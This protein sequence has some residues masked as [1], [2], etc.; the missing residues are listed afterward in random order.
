M[1][2]SDDLLQ[3][4]I[5]KQGFA[6]ADERDHQAEYKAFKSR[7]TEKLC[8]TFSDAKDI[9]S[10]IFQKLPQWAQRNDLVGWV[11]ASDAMSPD[12]AGE[13]ARLSKENASL[14][15]AAAESGA[16][17]FDGVSFEQM[18]G[19]LKSD[20]IRSDHRPTFGKEVV[21]AGLAFEHFLTQLSGDLTMIG[22]MQPDHGLLE[23]LVR[24]GLVDRTSNATMNVFKLT[25]TGRR[26]RNRLMAMGESRL[27]ALWTD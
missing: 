3:T 23:R 19:I 20:F 4:R 16:A 24:H 12:M 5:E 13:L 11:R 8:S 17:M 10:T 9:R 2:M 22:V 14:R 1:V 6:A 27:K 7:V 26:F 18:V 21:H 25:A 15:A